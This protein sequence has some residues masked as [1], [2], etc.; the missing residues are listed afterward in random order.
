[1]SYK[2][3][4]DMTILFTAVGFAIQSLDALTAAHLKNFDVSKDISFRFSPTVL[5]SGQI[6]IAMIF[7]TH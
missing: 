1:D 5:P 4:A 2:R 6:G 7:K 3:F